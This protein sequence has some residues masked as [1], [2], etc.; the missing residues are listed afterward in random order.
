MRHRAAP[1]RLRPARRNFTATATALLAALAKAETDGQLAERLTY[2]TKP[3]L[4]VID[5]LGY[6]RFERRSAH[7]FFRLV[8]RRYAREAAHH[9]QSGRDAV[10]RRLW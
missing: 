9:H 8:A 2:Y 6:L 1:R 10:G 5:E 7:L 4:L 3:K